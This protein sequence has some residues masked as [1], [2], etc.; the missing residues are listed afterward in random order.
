MEGGPGG[1]PVVLAT[2]CLDPDAGAALDN[3][4]KL[5]NIAAWLKGTGND[6]WIPG[7]L[8]PPTRSG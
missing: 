8:E 5:A 2:L 7:C 6:L 3:A 1:H 4:E